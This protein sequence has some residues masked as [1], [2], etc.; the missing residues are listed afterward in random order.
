MGR[1][2][3]TL[4]RAHIAFWVIVLLCVAVELVLTLSDAGIVRPGFRR[5][6]YD[7]GGFWPGLMVAGWTPNY[8]SQPWLMFISY[9]FLHTGA[10]HLV[11]NMITLVSVGRVVTD[12]VGGRGFCLLYAASLLGGGFGFG[13]LSDSLRPMV[14]ASGALFG[15]VGGVMAW[16]YVDRFFEEAGLWPV[17]RG[18]LLLIGLNL[19][20]WWAMSGLLAWETHL[21]GFIAGWVAALLIDPRPHTD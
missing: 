10:I 15:L 18:V 8:A 16:A 2:F 1:V 11:V 4:E 9:G 21:G 14:G 17:F 7:N 12:R 19:V 3:Q 20:L 13:F 5:I 6:A